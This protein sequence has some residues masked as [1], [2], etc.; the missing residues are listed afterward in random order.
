MFGLKKRVNKNSRLAYR[1]VLARVPVSQERVL[2]TIQKIQPC[3]YVQVSERLGII[4]G[5]VTPRIAELRHRHLIKIDHIG[6][7]AF[8]TRVNYY[9]LTKKGAKKLKEMQ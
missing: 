2:A 7:G 5:S 6:P 3:H 9:S 8:G 4:E 1:N